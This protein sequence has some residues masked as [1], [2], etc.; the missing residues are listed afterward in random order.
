[1]ITR[2]QMRQTLAASGS[3]GLGSASA[4]TQTT[5]NNVVQITENY[6]IVLNGDNNVVRGGGYNGDQA[7]TGTQQSSDNQVNTQS[8]VKNVRGSG[9]TTVTEKRTLPL[10]LNP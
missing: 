1:M 4:Q 2:E 3:G 10:V 8:T 5:M 9:T 6:E 7:S